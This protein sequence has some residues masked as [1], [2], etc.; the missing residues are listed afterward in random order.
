[1]TQEVLRLYSSTTGGFELSRL[2]KALAS[3][4][5]EGILPDVEEEACFYVVVDSQQ[6]AKELLNN[7]HALQW[8]LSSNVFTPRLSTKS[9]FTSLDFIVEVGPRLN[10]ITPFS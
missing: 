2:T 7:N 10:F 5:G 3:F 4:I 9:K 1:M 8:L 6:H